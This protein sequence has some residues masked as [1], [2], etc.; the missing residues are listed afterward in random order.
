[1]P[2]HTPGPWTYDDGAVWDEAGI[3]C[4]ATVHAGLVPDDSQDA[5]GRVL[6]ASTKMYDL[7]ERVTNATTSIT[8]DDLYAEAER[9]LAEI[10]NEEP[11]DRSC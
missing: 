4:V 10:G 7:L 8:L 5:N 9:L 1:M 2:K 6:A 3:G 11:E